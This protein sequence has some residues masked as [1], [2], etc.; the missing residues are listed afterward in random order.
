MEALIAIAVFSV[1][2]VS[3]VGIFS[4]FLKNSVATKKA[5]RNA[6][7]AQYVLNLMAKTIR[8]STLP[9]SATPTIPAPFYDL[10]QLTM[11]DNSHNQCVIFKYDSADGKLKMAT[12]STAPSIDKCNPTDAP[13][14]NTFSDLTKPGEISNVLFTGTPTTAPDL[15]AT[16]PTASIIG[17]VSMAINI[18]GNE[19]SSKIQTTVSLRE[20]YK[21]N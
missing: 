21:E 17:R 18:P 10:T 2:M 6:E 1:V 19:A 8:T 20:D 15:A 13:G 16:T 9:I 4:N 14:L 11:F 12:D 3:I 5:Q 7:S